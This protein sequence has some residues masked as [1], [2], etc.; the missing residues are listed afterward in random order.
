VES[1][2]AVTDV[3][4]FKFAIKAHEPAGGS[5][6]KFCEWRMDVEVV[7]SKKV[8]GSEFA[9]MNLVKSENLGVTK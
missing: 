8:V 5:E 7:F 1:G 3:C 6:K 2:V 4:E 9:K